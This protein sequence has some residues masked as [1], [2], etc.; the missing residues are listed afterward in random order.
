MIL[1]RENSLPGGRC[2]SGGQCHRDG[3]MSIVCASMSDSDAESPRA[4][5]SSG[6]QAG[7]GGL[8]G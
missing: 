8:P 7:G 6:A 2:P 5:T 1:T 4:G 3:F